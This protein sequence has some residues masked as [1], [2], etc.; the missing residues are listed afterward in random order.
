M[1]DGYAYES[2]LHD[3]VS[4]PANFNDAGSAKALPSR[5]VCRQQTGTPCTLFVEP[6]IAPA[7]AFFIGMLPSTRQATPLVRFGRLTAKQ[8]LTAH[9]A[10]ATRRPQIQ[11]TLAR[12][13]TSKANHAS[14]SHFALARRTHFLHRKILH[15]HQ[16]ITLYNRMQAVIEENI[17][18]IVRCLGAW[19]YA[20]FA[21]LN[22]P[23]PTVFCIFL[24]EWLDSAL[25]WL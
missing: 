10:K 5:F 14:T 24:Q 11:A 3:V 6:A 18:F 8:A 12:G 19:D 20:K 25:G 7:C 23:P 22:K 1:C 15:A 13:K 16:S 4:I 21:A 17:Y 2:P 9:N